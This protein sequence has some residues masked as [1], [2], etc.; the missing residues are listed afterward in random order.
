MVGTSGALRIMARSPILD[1]DLRSWCYAFD[2][3]HWL[4]GGAINNGGVVLSWLK[5]T[6]S[7]AFPG[8][9]DH[10]QLTFEGLM[11]LAQKSGIGAGGVVCLPF[12]AGERSPNWNLNARALFFG[13]SLE[14]RLEHLTRAILEGIAFR[15]KS[16]YEVLTQISGEITEIRTSGGFTQSLFWPQIL[17][18]V[19][20]R[21][22]L[23][24]CWTETSN[25]GAAIWAMLGTGAIHS[26]EEAASFNSVEQECLPKEEENKIY[27]AT[28]RIYQRLYQAVS[29]LFEETAALQQRVSKK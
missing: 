16:I 3:D 27:E 29:P 28:Y 18:E 11:A 9:G 8:L 19:L 12:F 17:A 23:I 7:Q 4:V 1:K 6:L 14:H 20:N 5:D 13:L 24:P 15:L 22:L 10:S 2:K 25:L 26:L 21:K